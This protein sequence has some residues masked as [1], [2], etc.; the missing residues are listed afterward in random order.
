MLARGAAAEG[1]LKDAADAA[2]EGLGT[3][4]KD[5]VD[6]QRVRE[7]LQHYLGR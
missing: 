1:T 4:T 2:L 5:P 3:L 6:Q 7:D